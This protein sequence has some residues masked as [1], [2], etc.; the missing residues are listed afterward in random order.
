MKR[1]FTLVFFFISAFG[2][3]LIQAQSSNVNAGVIARQYLV[4]HLKELGLTSDDLVGMTVQDQYTDH[5]SGITRIYFLQHKNEIPVYNAI[6]NLNI[7]KE[8]KVFYAGNRFVSN[9]ASRI[10]TTKTRLDAHDAIQKLVLNHGLPWSETRLKSR[11]YEDHFVFDQG[12]VAR[13]DIVVKR[14]YQPDGDK[15]RLAWDV[16]WSPVAGNDKWSARIDAVT[17]ALINE[18]NWTTYCNQGGMAV[19]GEDNSCQVHPDFISDEEAPACPSPLVTGA[20]YNVWPAPVQSP[21]RGPRTIVTNPA[22]PIAS[23][24]GW[25]DVDGQ[26]GPEYTITEGNNV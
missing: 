11:D 14:C 16:L 24:F 1:F 19:Y 3:L 8:G 18:N 23:P 22:D 26:P 6:L 7:T 12:Q 5:E 15:V 9:L 17:G 4:S 21:N 2:M 25:H 10:N 13:E 20:Q